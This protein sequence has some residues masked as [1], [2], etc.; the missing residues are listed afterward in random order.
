LIVKGVAEA[1]TPPTARP[2]ASTQN[3][4]LKDRNILPHPELIVKT[5]L[6]SV[7]LQDKGGI[8]HA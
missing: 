3:A 4:Q 1:T 8:L 6:V 2:E 5:I 7:G